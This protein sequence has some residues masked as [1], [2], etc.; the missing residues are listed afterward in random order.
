MKM[1]GVVELTDVG[2]HPI[3]E[4]KIFQRSI[5]LVAKSILLADPSIK[6][7]RLFANRRLAGAKR[8]FVRY[9]PKRDVKPFSSRSIRSYLHVISE[10]SER[11]SL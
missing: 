5:C 6:R 3:Q 10:T 9:R 11:C 4:K 7:K 8:E 1:V 2:H